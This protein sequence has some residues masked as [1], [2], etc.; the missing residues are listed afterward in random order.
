[1]SDSS[2]LLA[3]PCSFVNTKVPQHVQHAFHALAIDEHR[4][5]FSL[6]LWEQ[7]D[8]P[9]RDNLLKQCWFPGLYSN[10]D[11]WPDARL[12]LDPFTGTR[13]SSYLRDCLRSIAPLKMNRAS[14]FIIDQNRA[15]FSDTVLGREFL[16]Y[17]SAIYRDIRP[18]NILR[19]H[20]H[21]MEI[22]KFGE[23]YFGHSNDLL[24]YVGLSG[25]SMITPLPLLRPQAVSFGPISRILK[26]MEHQYPVLNVCSTCFE[27]IPLILE[28][29]YRNRVR[30]RCLSGVR[31][32]LLLLQTVSFQDWG[33]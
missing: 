21:H 8:E 9:H 13:D 2:R 33:S 23:S 25:S 20:D 1:M 14:H 31:V 12:K 27:E 10:M 22:S 16:H 3:L 5:L 4:N 30:P 11:G 28:C 26:T 6:T 7:P 18:L 17:E 19:T 15:A 32:S 24:C 29:F